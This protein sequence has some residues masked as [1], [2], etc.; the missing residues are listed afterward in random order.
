VSPVR[1]RNGHDQ[2][3][4]VPSEPASENVPG[5]LSMY[6]RPLGSV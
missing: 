1:I 3:A 4:G 5:T 6:D 2:V